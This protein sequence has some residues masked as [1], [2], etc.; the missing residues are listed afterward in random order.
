MKNV[1]GLSSLILGLALL[2]G[3]ADSNPTNDPAVKWLGS[4]SINGPVAD[5][6]NASGANSALHCVNLVQTQS[7]KTVIDISKIPNGITVCQDEL[8][9]PEAVLTRLNISNEPEAVVLSGKRVGTYQKITATGYHLYSLCNDEPGPADY[10]NVCKFQA[11]GN[12]IS[13]ILLQ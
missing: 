7:G 4:L 13:S 5:K 6:I 10:T 2:V 9:K 8:A 3:C 11:A 12:F 1:I